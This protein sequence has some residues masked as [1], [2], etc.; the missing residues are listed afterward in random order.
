MK[1]LLQAILNAGARKLNLMGAAVCF[2]LF[3]YALFAER[4]QGL[5]PC[6]LCIL[7]RVAVAGMGLGFLL[8]AIHSPAGRFRH[9]YS[10]LCG[11]V[12]MAGA[13]VAV[14][15]LW[16]QSQPEGSVP[17]CGASFDFILENFGVMTAVKEALTASGEMLQSRL[18]SA[19]PFHARLGPAGAAW[20]HRLGR[21]GQLLRAPLIRLQ[22]QHALPFGQRAAR[23]IAASTA[24]R[25]GSPTGFSALW[26]G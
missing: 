20:P 23:F 16:I 26:S 2:L 3:G 12:A 9:A 24:S 1:S 8:A 4:V 7:Q 14:R 21:L 18:V 5:V 11:A 13:G 25:Q 22:Q 15:H 17:P 19:G 10:V 6:P